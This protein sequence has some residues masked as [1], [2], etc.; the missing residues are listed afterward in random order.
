MSQSSIQFKGSLFTLTVLQ[1]SLTDIRKLNASLKAKIQL[2]PNF[3]KHAPIVVD[4][5]E[6]K[7]NARQLD[8]AALHDLLLKNDLVPV[9]IKGA[10]KSLHSKIVAAGFAYISEST[11]QSSHDIK[12]KKETTPPQKMMGPISQETAIEMAQDDNHQFK[13]I[14]RPV[15]S[16]QQVYSSGD[17]VIIAPVSPGAELLAEGNIHIYDRMRGRALAGINGDTSARVFCKQ[18]EAELV[19]IAGEYQVFEHT[20]YPHMSKPTQIY[21]DDG[22]LI[23]E[24]L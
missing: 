9:G 13:L 18:L 10:S 24:P 1:I 3:F 22:K 15:R 2:A 17:L 6:L 23:A 20:N 12:P 19:S 16:G 11:T 5:T 4:V 14:T 21:L 8:F 7:D